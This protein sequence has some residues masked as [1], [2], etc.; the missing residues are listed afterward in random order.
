M[1]VSN[2]NDMEAVFSLRQLTKNVDTDIDLTDE[3]GVRAFVENAAEHALANSNEVAAFMSLFE[4]PESAASVARAC[5][6]SVQEQPSLLEDQTDQLTL[7]LDNPPRTQQMDM[8]I[9]LGLLALAG[10]AMFLSG[11][12]KIKTKDFK[13]EYQGSD[14]VTDIFKAV[15]PKIPGRLI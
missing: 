6:A 4:Q 1:N 11:S 12:L 13:L 2:L 15:L 14:K 5:L 7:I 3:A 10:M 8:G 9:S